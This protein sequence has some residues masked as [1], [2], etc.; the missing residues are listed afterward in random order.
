VWRR[1][2]RVVPREGDPDPL[3]TLGFGPAGDEQLDLQVVF[4]EHAAVPSSPLLSERLQTADAQIRMSEY[5]LTY[6][7][8]P[9]ELHT[10]YSRLGR[11]RRR[12]QIED[13]GSG[14]DL[15]KSFEQAYGCPLHRVEASIE[16]VACDQRT[17]KLLDLPLGFPMLWRERL[18]VGLDEQQREYGFTA[19]VGR[20]IALQS[21]V[22]VNP[23]R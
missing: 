4:A 11:A 13:C 1:T 19:Y 20:H 9:F 10:V 8:R 15:G 14:G 6:N 17:A 22:V 12:L 2:E 5:V 21:S 7:G 18:L 3:L 23:Q 16:A